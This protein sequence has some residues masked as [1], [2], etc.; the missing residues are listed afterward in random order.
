M[1]SLLRAN[2]APHFPV[3]AP[4]SRHAAT[5]ALG[6]GGALNLAA[7]TN[8]SSASAPLRSEVEKWKQFNQKQKQAIEQ[9]GHWVSDGR[10][11]LAKRERADLRTADASSGSNTAIGGKAPSLSL[12]LSLP[13]PLPLPTVAIAPQRLERGSE[14]VGGGGEGEGEGK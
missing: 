13:L 3:S 10:G 12:P 4:W 14:V 8:A 7:T 6:T 11:L 9:E 5:H 2:S 1:P